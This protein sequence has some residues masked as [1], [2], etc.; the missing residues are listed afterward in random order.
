MSSKDD[1]SCESKIVVNKVLNRSGGMLS[2][3]NAFCLKNLL[4]CICFVCSFQRSVVTMHD[5]P[6]AIFT[7]CSIEDQ[8]SL[9]FKLDMFRSVP[10]LI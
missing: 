2:I 7:D 1:G 10:D 8:H 3:L 4:S 6:A 5:R 9:Y